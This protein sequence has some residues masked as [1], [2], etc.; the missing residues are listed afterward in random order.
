MRPCSRAAVA[1]ALTLTAALVGAAPPAAAGRRPHPAA[2]VAPVDAPVRDPFRRPA[3]TWCP[4]NRGLEY[5][6]VPG[7]P[8]T[9]AAAGLVSFA[10]TVAGARWVVVDHADGLRTSY[11]HLASVA[12][13]VGRR[14]A[15]REELGTASDRLHLGVRRGDDYLDPAPLLAGGA[16]V[17]RL[18]PTGGGPARWP[19][20]G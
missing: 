13:T 3:C 6:T 8:V 10:G 7:Q 12:V 17:P 19:R 14:V 4:G 11:G 1:A 2:Y 15:A 20:A 9:A 5:T 16:L 18:V